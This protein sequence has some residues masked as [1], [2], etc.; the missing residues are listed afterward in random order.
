MLVER[1]TDIARQGREALET[2]AST[3]H[4]EGYTGA[5]VG[6]AAVA[7]VLLWW[8]RR[9]NLPPGPRGL[10]IFGNMFQFCEYGLK[11]PLK[12]LNTGNPFA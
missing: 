10:P 3:M 12:Y 5:L 4:L 11:S 8:L 2:L 9:P 1:L 7:A 6:G